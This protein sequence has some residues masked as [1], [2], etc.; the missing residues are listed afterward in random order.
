MSGI[1]VAFFGALGRDAELKTSKAGKAYLRLGVRVGDGDGA[2]WVSV[3]AFDEPTVENA[4]DFLKG[5]RV[6]VEGTLQLNE[7][8]GQD[9]AK[10]TGLQAM[11][12]HTR[13]AQIGRNRA[14]QRR[15]PVKRAGPID[16]DLNDQV[17]FE[18][19]R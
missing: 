3:L 16:P 13:L 11:S 5:A 17:P 8:T 19:P 10:R 14:S 6:Y 1:E 9:G 4:A 12:W 18:A 15:G 2:Q 7:W